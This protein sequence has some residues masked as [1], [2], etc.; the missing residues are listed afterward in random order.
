MY[1]Q[2]YHLI[3]VKS[4]AKIR[5][6]IHANNTRNNTHNDKVYSTLND[7]PD[8]FEKNTSNNTGNNISNDTG[9]NTLDDDS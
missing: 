1:T 5:F 8:M 2:H 4:H 3:C 9:N 7:T 6:I